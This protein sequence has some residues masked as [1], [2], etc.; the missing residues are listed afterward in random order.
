MN[1]FFKYL[2]H[3]VELIYPNNCYSCNIRLVSGEDIIC[4][5]CLYDLPRTNYHEHPEDNPVAELF[6]GISKIK[7]ATSYYV[8]EKGSKYRSLIHGLKYKNLPEIGIVMGKYF[9]S[10]LKG[11]A[12][13]GIDLLV[14]VPLHP[15]KKRIRGY[16]QS[17]MIGIGMA[18]TTGIEHDY[19]NLIRKVFTETQTKKNLE[20]RRKNVESVFG[21]KDPALF[22]GKHILLLDDVV[23]T[24]STLVACAEEIL[25]IPNTTVSVACLAIAKY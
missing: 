1:I 16:N 17:E 14:P 18:E 23:T 19:K 5:K 25:K 2:R 13:D 8:F 3:F 21:I 20:E 15:A 4:T 12:F 24:G 9:G 7:Y 10:E 11:S 22:K 6:Y